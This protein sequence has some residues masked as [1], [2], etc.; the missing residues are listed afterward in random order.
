MP[1]TVI[2]LLMSRLKQI[3]ITDVF[4]VP[5]DFA[6]A[7]ND[8]IDDDPDMP[9]ANTNVSTAAPPVNVSFFKPPVMV[10]L[11]E[12]PIMMS[13]KLEPV[14]FNLPVKLVA[15]ILSPVAVVVAVTVMVKSFEPVMTNFELSVFVIVVITLAAVPSPVD[16][17]FTV[18]KPVVTKDAI[19][20]P[21]SYRSCFITNHQVT[22]RVTNST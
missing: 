5:G 6:F 11:P 8:A 7:L 20:K 3:G 16:L 19:V 14:A 2:E 12:P 22:C 4:G 10:S 15:S 21:C 17:I 9:A 1:Q 13:A 18:V